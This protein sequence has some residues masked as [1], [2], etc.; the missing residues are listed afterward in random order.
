M[1]E[2]DKFRQDFGGIEMQIWDRGGKMV[3]NTGKV[4]VK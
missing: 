2:E 3:K 4:F 1:E